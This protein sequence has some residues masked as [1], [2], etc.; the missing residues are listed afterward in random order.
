MHFGDFGVA[1]LICCDFDVLMV[2][3]WVFS[4]QKVDKSPAEVKESSAES[5]LATLKSLN[6]K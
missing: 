3:F 5:I 6:L 4:L 2:L 1:V